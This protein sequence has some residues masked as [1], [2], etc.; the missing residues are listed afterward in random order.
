MK[1]NMGWIRTFGSRMCTLEAWKKLADERLGNLE[2]SVYSDLWQKHEDRLVNLEKNMQEI[3]DQ[4]KFLREKLAAHTV[5]PHH[6]GM[7]TEKEMEDL[8]HLSDR[9]KRLE[10][11]RRDD[12]GD[13]H[14]W[15]EQFRDLELEQ[16]KQASSEWWK[17][18]YVE[19]KKKHDEMIQKHE[20]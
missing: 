2:C 3:F 18:Q 10:V 16:T 7:P 11:Q 13:F 19:L 12:G 6:R 9:I 8:V 1:I 5:K 15:A 20:E 4:V 17:N 14:D